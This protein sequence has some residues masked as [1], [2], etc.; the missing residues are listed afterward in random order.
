KISVGFLIVQD[1]IAVFVLFFFSA[2]ASGLPLYDLLTQTLL[3]GAG[4]L[5]MLGGISY[6]VLPKLLPR[7]SK[8][9]EWLFLFSIAWL[10]I[11]ASTFGM[12]GFSTEIGALLAGLS[13]A[14]TLYHFEI[15]A[16]LK[17]IRDFFIIIFFIVLGSEMVITS[18]GALIVPA[19]ILSAIVLIGNPLIVMTIMRFE[20]YSKRTGFLA[21]LTVAQISEFSLIIMTLGL[22]LGTLT[23]EIVSMITF[24]AIFTITGSTYMI[25][26]G[27]KLYQRLSPILNMFEK[28]ELTRAPK[29]KHD[30]SKTYPILLF[31]A[32]ITGKTVLDSL[33]KLRKNVLVVDFDPEE[34]IELAEEGTHC[35]FGDATDIELLR[36]LEVEK[37][38]MI[39]SAM[40]SVDSNRSLLN[41]VRKS[42]PKAIVMMTANKISEALLLYKEGAD[43]IILP[44]FLGGK[45]ASFIIE[46]FRLN[47]T[48][49]LKAKAD[50]IIELKKHE[51]RKHVLVQNLF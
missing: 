33:K 16:R 4:A 44:H 23:Q 12:I 19:A 34:I 35:R 24:V 21:G 13:L 50:H 38:E 5:A 28:E 3:Q 6:F 17:P 2:S 46:N 42:N 8:S 45:H 1:I 7:I 30:K 47:G 40:P 32:G 51:R 25:M 14:P 9:Q 41:Y 29:S 43:Y 18:I 11:V 39:V 26:G 27:N 49:F 48:K 15:T 31:G 20:G 36:E 10:F 22:K 37:A